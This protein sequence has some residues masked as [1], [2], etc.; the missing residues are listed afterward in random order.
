MG[1]NFGSSIYSIDARLKM[2]NILRVTLV[3]AASVA[4]LSAQAIVF[5]DDFSVTQVGVVN[6]D[7]SG[8][9]LG[10]AADF[11]PGVRRVLGTSILNNSLP[12][13]ARSTA[14]I[15]D[16]ALSYSSDFEVQGD[17]FARYDFATPQDF[18][19]FDTFK[20]DLLG[21]DLRGAVT[22]LGQ[23]A[24]GFQSVRSV[25]I[26]PTSTPYSVMISDAFGDVDAS[27]ITKVWLFVGGDKGM[28]AAVTGFQTVP[29]PAT[30]AIL[31]LGALALLR[32]RKA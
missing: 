1:Q 4:A 19:G 9:T 3:T 5:G 16:G 7:V 31:G 26:F 2:K 25:D 13:F 10:P 17:G 11:A 28:D 32:R 15:H 29:E 30:M 18:T 23:S 12:G 14:S 6:T 21:N 20:I 22:I 8:T 24:N 27:K